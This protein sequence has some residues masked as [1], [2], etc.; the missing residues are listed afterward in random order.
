MEKYC[1]S[2]GIYSVH[3]K[4]LRLNRILPCCESQGSYIYSFAEFF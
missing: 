1:L 3:G 2:I 4:S